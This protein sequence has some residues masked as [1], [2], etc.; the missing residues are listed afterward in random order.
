MVCQKPN[1][2][3]K[4]NNGLHCENGPALTYND[5]VT[6][7]YSLNGVVMPKEYVM[8]PEEKFDI[9]IILKESHKIEFYYY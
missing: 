3:K 2:I 4:N 9:N 5:G 8:M 7:I 6:E 1:L